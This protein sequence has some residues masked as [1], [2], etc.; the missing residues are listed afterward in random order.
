MQPD[1]AITSLTE[2]AKNRFH[3]RPTEARILS[4]MP[5]FPGRSAV[6]RQ[7]EFKNSAC[8]LAV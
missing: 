1:S 4:G 8:F 2:A 3:C 5:D 7:N 6:R